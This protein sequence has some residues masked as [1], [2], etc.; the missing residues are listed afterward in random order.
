M[1]L[2]FRTAVI[3]FMHRFKKQKI[4][5]VFSPGFPKDEAD[6][7]CL[8]AQQSLLRCILR[9]YP[10]LQP[11]VLGFQYPYR[12][13][14]YQW[15]GIAV[16]P[17]NG[18]NRGGLQRIFTWL[19]AWRIT[20][21]ILRGNDCIGILSFWLGECAFAGYHFAKWLHL[22]HVT[23]VLGQDAKAGNRY[24]N[25][26]PM[27][28]IQLAAVSESCMRQLQL[29]YA[30][31]NVRVIPN[32]IDTLQFQQVHPERSIDIIG[33][34]SLTPLKQYDLLIEA[35][36]GLQKQ[37]QAIR[38]VLCGKGPEENRLRQLAATRGVAGHI[39]LKGEI[40]HDSVLLLL[41]QSRILLHPSR[42]EGF[43]GAC[44]EALYAGAHVV[45]FVKAQD[46]PI[47]HWHIVHDLE[48]MTEK[49]AELLRE[50]N[51]DQRPVLPYKM[52]ETVKQMIMLLGSQSNND[53]V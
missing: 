3:M 41:Q 19:S 9:E 36:A 10:G 49:L 39:H 12:S 2:F 35:V 40:P 26:L 14:P 44:L 20:K 47:D 37:F 7:A 28:K 25:W 22:P 17:L 23:W 5:L 42:Y 34:G 46:A 6:S 29:H 11:V 1:S 50:E 31:K 45:S 16:Y 8:P 38:V 15:N 51:L 13:E 53:P 21:K 24:A 48:E 27:Q 32:G 33:C 30:V 4:I 18:R 43:S 52:Q